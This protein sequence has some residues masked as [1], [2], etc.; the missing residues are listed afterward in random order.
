MW[1]AL[2]AGGV[3]AV[4]LLVPLP[5]LLLL[6]ALLLMLLCTLFAF[7]NFYIL[8]RRSGSTRRRAIWTAFRRLFRWL[9]LIVP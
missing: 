9:S 8:A 4:G 2:T 3:L 1:I 7:A 5:G 6:L